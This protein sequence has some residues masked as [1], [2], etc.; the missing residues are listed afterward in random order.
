MTESQEPLQLLLNSSEEK[1]FLQVLQETVERKGDSTFASWYNESGKLQVEY[2]FCELW[3]EAGYIAH[4]LLVTHHL[5]KGDRVVLCY[6]LGLQFFAAFLGC[7]RAGIV[8]VLIY[9]PSPVNMSKSLEKMNKVVNDSKAKLV[10]IDDVINLL[11]INPFST[12]RNHWPSNVIWKVHSMIP[13]MIKTFVGFGRGAENLDSFLYRVEILPEDLAFLQYTSGSTGDPKGVKVTFR[14]LNA[15]AKAIREAAH[16]HMVKK[17]VAPDDIVGFSWLPQYHDMVSI[18]KSLLL[19]ST[20][21]TFVSY[22]RVLIGP[23]LCSYCA[24]YCRIQMSSDFSPCIYS[25]SFTLD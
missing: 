3:E 22:M 7:L 23:R 9:P 15:N 20:V 24:F 25:E 16:A 13:R 10:L 2:T 19:I 21:F 18:I 1:H 11:R 4:D 8:A 6:N 5:S 14:A 17:G 12:S